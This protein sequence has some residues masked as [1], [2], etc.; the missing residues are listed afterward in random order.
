[1]ARG[2]HH[3]VK[4]SLPASLGRPPTA[5]AI[6]TLVDLGLQGAGIEFDSPDAPALPVGG[7]TRLGFQLDGRSVVVHVQI[8]YRRDDTRRRYGLRFIRL[9]L[10]D[11]AM[12]SALNKLVNQRAAFRV[13]PGDAEK[14]VVRLLGSDGARCSAPLLD[15]SASGMA[16]KVPAK[17][18]EAMCRESRARLELSLPRHT[19]PLQLVGVIRHRVL[20]SDGV[21]FGMHFD[22]HHVSFAGAENAIMAYVMRR[23]RD[24]LKRD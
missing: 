21:R 12:R 16:V 8:R 22:R 4:T 17:V 10:L 13:S 24:A 3:R 18:E 2:H 9:E 7:E 20:L 11:R 19:T 1:M 23:Q 5:T 15:L 6:G 14:I